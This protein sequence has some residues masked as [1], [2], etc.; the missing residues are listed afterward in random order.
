MCL[1]LDRQPERWASMLK[2]FEQFEQF[3]IAGLVRRIPAVD[4]PEDH[5]IG[6]AL[7]H[8][9][10]L[11]LAR[12][13]NLESVLV[14]EDDAVFLHG[15]VWVLR[16]AVRELAD[17]AWNLLYLGAFDQGR[18][19]PLVEGC[20]Y[21]EAVRGVTTTHALAYHHRIYDR[22]LA[23]LPEDVVGM[24]AW[25][26]SNNSI[27]KYLATTVTTGVRRV[28]PQVAAQAGLLRYADVDLCDQFAVDPL[29][30]S[31]AARALDKVLLSPARQLADQLPAPPWPGAEAEGARC[32]VGPG[33]APETGCQL[34]ADDQGRSLLI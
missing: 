22:L 30:P 18:R 14:I 29:A 6:C 16:R 8:R 24:R 19:F 10:A 26:N 13:E 15:A 34:I 11:E 7:S 33:A 2:R 9:R 27:D 17:Q 12:R 3:G 4:T 5:H 21:L 20:T 28:R 1:N 25:L 23:E 32:A 31:A